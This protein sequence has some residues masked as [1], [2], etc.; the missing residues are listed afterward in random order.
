[1]IEVVN[2]SPVGCS[3]C[4]DKTKLGIDFT[5]A[6][7]PIVDIANKTIFGYEALVRGPNNEGA[8]TILSQVNDTNRY[9]FDQAIRVKA[10]DLAKRLGLEGML[11]INFLP[12]AVYKPETCIRATLEAAKEMDFPTDRIM[13]EVTEGEKVIDND[14][15]R[16][17]FVEYKKHQFTT[18]IDDFGAGYAGLNLLADWQPDIIKLDMSLTR[19]VDSDR[20]R[21]SLVFGIISI[22]KQ[23]DIKVIAEG[24]ET[25]EECLTLADE[26]VSLFQGYFFA[27]PGFES[28]PEIPEAVWPLVK[29]RRA[30]NRRYS[31]P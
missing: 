27:R 9:R 16:N 5:M 24:I 19:N 25:K 18:A 2:F 12:N 3:E 8:A 28:L 22:C 15:L 11:S 14:H 1:M 23:L 29:N 21:R 20:V 31:L 6:F 17:I 30:K 10:I 4:R 26:G 7:Q 13:F